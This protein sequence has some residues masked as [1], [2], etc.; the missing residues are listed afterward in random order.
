TGSGSGT[1]T[2]S[3]SG[4]GSA[5]AGLVFSAY[6]DT[7]INMNWNTNVIT[8]NV[9]G[10]PTPLAQD[11]GTNGGGAITLAFATGECGSENWGGVQGAAL[12]SANLPL[13]GAAHVK[14]ILSTGG[15]AGSFSCG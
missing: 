6:K 9:S 2:G 7:T 15:A 10:T 12:A 1:G 11:L 3:G 5:P 14:Y 13:L 8:T 4:S